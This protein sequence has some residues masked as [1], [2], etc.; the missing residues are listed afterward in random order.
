L[1]RYAK[2]IDS[3]YGRS[4]TTGN[5]GMRYFIGDGVCVCV[6]VCVCGDK[7]SG[8]VIDPIGWQERELTTRM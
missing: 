6:C 3:S 8:N 1:G 5:K 7:F 4:V 2:L